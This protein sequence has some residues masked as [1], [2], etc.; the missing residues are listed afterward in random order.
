MI[1]SH[2]MCE[3]HYKQLFYDK[4]VKLFERKKYGVVETLAKGR[5]G[6]RTPALPHFLEQEFFFLCKIGKLLL[7]NNMWVTVYLMNI[8]Y[9]IR[10][11]LLCQYGLF[12]YTYVS[13]NGISCLLWYNVISWNNHTENLLFFLSIICYFFWITQER[14]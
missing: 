9:S 2:L 12:I 11:P 7:S 3:L 6:G 14:W 13:K 4:N 10:H 8:R 1:A 5:G